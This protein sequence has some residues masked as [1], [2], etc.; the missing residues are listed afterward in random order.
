M[1]IEEAQR[2]SQRPSGTE[3]TTYTPR[4]RTLGL[5]HDSKTWAPTHHLIAVV[6][7]LLS[8]SAQPWCVQGELPAQGKPR[9]PPCPRPQGKGESESEVLLTGSNSQPT[10]TYSQAGPASHSASSPVINQL[11]F[12]SSSWHTAPNN[13]ALPPTPSCQVFSALPTNAASPWQGLSP[14]ARWQMY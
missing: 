3:D 5:A 2:G 11:H 9:C 12:F 10:E 14:E 6:R 4:A 8:P 13:T 7:S 1:A